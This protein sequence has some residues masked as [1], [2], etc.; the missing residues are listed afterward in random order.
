MSRAVLVLPPG[1]FT[2]A[3]LGS[4]GGDHPRI[5]EAD[6]FRQASGLPT[7][8]QLDAASELDASV[9]GQPI[10]DMP[11]G[12]LLA[13][14]QADEAQREHRPVAIVADRGGWYAALTV[15]GV[16]SFADG[17]HLVHELAAAEQ[18]SAPV[19]QVVYPLTD[20]AWRP[21][22]AL[23][24]A[25]QA[26][27]RTVDGEA[28]ALLDLGAFGIV[29]G[30]QATIDRLLATLRPVQV[31]DRRYPRRVASAGHA[32][33]APLPPSVAE[34]LRALEWRPPQI[35]LIDGR[36]ARHTP[37]SADPADLRDYTLTTMPAEAF[38]FASALRV[39]L[40]E[41][42]PDVVLLLGPGRSPASAV[43]QL[44]VAEGYHGLRTRAAYEADQRSAT[45]L[46]QRAAR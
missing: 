40:R 28:T 5:D 35:T 45:P 30:E 12:Y 27:L 34:H 20:A 46:V 4:L 31:A 39:A 23:R 32:R 13:V 1:G 38:G 24:A 18:Q 29:A 7:L 44:V 26:A 22:P 15:A 25:L 21:Q 41:Y 10:H 11:L 16:L 33:V 37:W 36:G 42:A 2:A 19:A 3:S 8:R 6:A 9:H 14:L 17:L 43:A